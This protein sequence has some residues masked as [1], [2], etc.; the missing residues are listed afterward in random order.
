MPHAGRQTV[1][2]ADRD[3]T[4][5][6]EVTQNF[7]RVPILVTRKTRE[8]LEG[9]SDVRHGDRTDGVT[10]FCRPPSTRSLSGRRDAVPPVDV[11]GVWAPFANDAFSPA[12]GSISTFNAWSTSET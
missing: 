8:D 2:A 7:A 10:P 6:A 5:E 4:T 11:L 1:V 3:T 12:K 9:C